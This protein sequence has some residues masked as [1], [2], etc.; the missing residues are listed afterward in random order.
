MS[1]GKIHIVSRRKGHPEYPNGD[2]IYVGDR[3]RFHV[4]TASPLANRINR[5]KPDCDSETRSKALED[6]RNWLISEY[7]HTTPVRREI[8]RILN[9]VSSGNDVCLECWCHPLPCHADIIKEFIEGMT[10]QE[11]NEKTAELKKRINQVKLPD[12]IQQHMDRLE[13]KIPDYVSQSEETGEQA[14]SLFVTLQQCAVIVDR[15]KQ[16]RELISGNGNK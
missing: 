16:V 15:Y 14:L 8:N 5:P 11:L 10:D 6:Y 4:D 3:V 12:R 1:I 7:D 13:S 9:I 2:V